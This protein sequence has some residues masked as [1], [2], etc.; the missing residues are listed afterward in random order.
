MFIN[1]DTS[2]V[3]V[4]DR[5]EELPP[6]LVARFAHAASTLVGDAMGRFGLMDSGIS[7]LDGRARCAG[8]ALTVL[9]REGDNLA[10]HVALDHAE[11]GDVLIIDAQGGS[12]R[13]VFGDLLAEICM[14]RGIAGVIIDGLSR[15]AA[16]ISDLG[17]AVWA[18]GLSPAGPFKNGPG[19]VGAPVA[20]GGVVVNPGDLIVADA[21]GVAVIPAGRIAAVAREVERLEAAEDRLRARIRN[22]KG[23][24][25]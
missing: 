3:H 12:A 6:D 19:A 4:H 25:P 17:L 16:A 20:C 5:T 23:E 8:R 10:I 2:T 18:R 14:T 9:T 15:D 11:P 13:A 21:D 1:A 24:R 7:A 22:S